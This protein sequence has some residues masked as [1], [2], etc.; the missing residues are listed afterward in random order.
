MQV[1][2]R[3]NAPVAADH[4][5]N[6]PVEGGGR[7]LGEACH[8]FD[9]ANTL[10]GTP[11]RVLAAALPAPHG[12]T[13][14]ETATVTIQYED[15]SLA[16]VHYSGVGSPALPKERIEVL[17]GGRSWVLDDFAELTSFDR[18]RATQAEKRQDKGH[19]AL[20]ARAIAACRGEA[21]FEPGLEAAYTAQSVALA[22]LESIASGTPTEVLAPPD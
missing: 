1:V 11:K 7:I 10:C 13:T 18:G 4:W 16:T 15:G 19:A 17:R 3:V 14:V 22:A 6:D 2:Y 21:S 8:M 12:M 9:F 20:L 5:L